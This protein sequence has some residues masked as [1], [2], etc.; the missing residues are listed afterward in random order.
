M[1]KFPNGIGRTSQPTGRLLLKLYRP[2][3]YRISGQLSGYRRGYRRK[4]GLFEDQYSELDGPVLVWTAID[5][6]VTSRYI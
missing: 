4:T 5:G 3:K 1:K 2:G 6:G